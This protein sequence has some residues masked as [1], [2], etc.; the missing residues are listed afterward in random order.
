MLEYDLLHKLAH[1]IIERK[2]NDDT[3]KYH[4]GAVAIS[5]TGHILSYGFN[6]YSKT[7]PLQYKH[8]CLSNDRHG[9]IYLHAEI[10]AIVK[11]KKEIDTLI[12]TRML[13]DNSFAIAKPCP[14]CQSAIREAG[15]RKVYYTNY[16]G[17]LILLNN[18]D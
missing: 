13:K 12:V 17:E 18:E 2:E 15:I 1:K 5:K 3:C 8:S 16:N 9:R 6:S 4:M 11:A 10:S 14:I 7:H